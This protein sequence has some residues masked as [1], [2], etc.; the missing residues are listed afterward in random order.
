MARVI[1]ADGDVLREKLATYVAD[2]S[3]SSTK[4][5]FV[6]ALSGGSMPKL[7]S[8]LLEH[9]PREMR[10]TATASRCISLATGT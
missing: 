4:P 8:G 7:L 9:G 5:R 6:V 3:A 10:D 1:I 2:L